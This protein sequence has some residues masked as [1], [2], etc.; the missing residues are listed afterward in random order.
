L[1][2]GNAGNYNNY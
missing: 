2:G 1:Q